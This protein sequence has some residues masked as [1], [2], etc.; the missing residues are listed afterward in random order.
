MT[1][2]NGMKYT[3]LVSDWLMSDANG[4]MQFGNGDVYEGKCVRIQEMLFQFSSLTLF[5]SLSF[6]FSFSLSPS[7]PLGSIEK[8]EMTGKGKFTSIKGWIYEGTP[9]LSLSLSLSL[10]SLPSY[11]SSHQTPNYAFT[12]SRTHEGDWVSGVRHGR[13]R[14]WYCKGRVYDGEWNQGRRHGT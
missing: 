3:G 12:H 9:P 6:S 4:R 8:G 5:L 7:P 11:P 1:L 10:P 13:G 14:M 2:H